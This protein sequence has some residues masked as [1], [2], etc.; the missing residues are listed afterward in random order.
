MRG[1]EGLPEEGASGGCVRLRCQAWRSTRW[2]VT[3]I[4]TIARA[5]A[6]HL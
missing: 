6:Q 4:A 1:G 2:T 3:V 5:M